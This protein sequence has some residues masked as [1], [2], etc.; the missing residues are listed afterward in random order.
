VLAERRAK[1]RAAS[2]WPC[3]PSGHDPS[4]S[5]VSRSCYSTALGVSR[6]SKFR[7]F[8]FANVIDRAA[9]RL[10]R[11]AHT[12]PSLGPWP[13]ATP[14]GLGPHPGSYKT[15]VKNIY[16]QKSR[17]SKG[18]AIALLSE[19]SQDYSVFSLEITMARVNLSGMTVEALMDLR[20]RVDGL[21]HRRRAELEKQCRLRDLIR[22]GNLDFTY[23]KC[24]CP[25]ATQG[26]PA[27]NYGRDC[28]TL[29]SNGRDVGAILIEEGLAVPFICGATHCPRT[30]RPWCH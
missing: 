17:R 15:G 5:S 27:C 2:F 19:T 23:V 26:T 12:A 13:P 16:D 25:A 21:L 18:F 28:G 3:W 29:K 1:A 9:R 7:S 20:E 22:A 6:V 4:S 10:A 8:D 11:G 24:S 14:H 30:P